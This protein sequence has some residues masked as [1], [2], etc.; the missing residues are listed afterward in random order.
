MK[1]IG[2]I[3]ILVGLGFAV[4]LFSN[5]AVIA[6]N[7]GLSLDLAL[8]IPFFVITGLAIWG[9]FLLTDKEYRINGAWYSL[10]V[11]ALQ[12]PIIYSDA[13][14]YYFILGPYLRLSGENI[15]FYGF[16]AS[17]NISLEQSNTPTKVSINLAA[18]I[19]TSLLLGYIVRFK[20]RSRRHRQPI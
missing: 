1:I 13:F 3:Q 10:P 6:G 17:M 20:G 19:T 5:A 2:L 12:I 14:S 15:R 16:T 9:G 18:V 11:H 7:E 8:C 4:V